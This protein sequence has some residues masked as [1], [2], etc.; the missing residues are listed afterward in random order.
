MAELPPLDQVETLT[1]LRYCYN[2]A[3]LERDFACA[4]VVMQNFIYCEP[5]IVPSCFAYYIKQCCTKRPLFY[6]AASSFQALEME[7]LAFV[8]CFSD[9]EP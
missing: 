5:E 9:M 7:E 3:I 1:Y 2:F 8:K 6:D 4:R